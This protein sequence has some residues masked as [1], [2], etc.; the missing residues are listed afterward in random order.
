MISKIGG[1]KAAMGLIVIIIGVAIG[2]YVPGGL[3]DN[4]LKLLIFVSVGFFLG[5][6][7][8]HLAQAI[9]KKKPLQLLDTSYLETQLKVVQ[10]QMN[11]VGKQNEATQKGLKFIIDAAG[12]S[13]PKPPAPTKDS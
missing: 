10:D 8:E 1:R 7:G 12:F 13:K 2:C 4:L 6:A 9:K 5:N 11:I 3:T